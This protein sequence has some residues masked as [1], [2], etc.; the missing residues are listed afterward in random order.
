[1]WQVAL[2]IL[3]DNLHMVLAMSP[4]GSA[5]RTRCRNFPGLVSCCTIDWYFEWP[6]E[7]LLAVAN[8]F[9]TNLT[10]PDEN[11][12]DI[13]KIISYVH[14]SVT[15][16]YSP[17][18]EAKFKRRNYATPKNYLDF[19]DGYAT[20]LDTNRGKVDTM[21]TRLASGLEKLISAAEQVATMSTE[22]SE[23]VIVVNAKKKEVEALINDINTKTE[24]ANKRQGEAQ[25]MA[26][27]IEEDNVVITREK[28]GADE[29]LAEALP[30]LAAAA[31]ALENLEK[32][33]IT[34]I[35]SMA[36]PPKPVMIVCMCVVIL[37][38]LGRE[39]ESAG[40]AGAKAM[41]SDTSLLRLLQEYKKDDMKERQI[42]KIKDLLAQEPE[43]FGGS[44]EKMA[45]VSKA[46]YGLLQWVN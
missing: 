34:E 13:A 20:L 11:R 28:A 21:S 15:S 42:K 43:I 17:S 41:L 44:G 30:A 25:S 12:S 26:K 22:L 9:L 24:A 4:A 46:G 18:F 32:K 10:L 35:K 7:A 3:K 38:P 2:N 16:N 45:S 37:R 29:A 14:T 5:L 1:V 36:S 40:W 39:D 31:E 33:D 6:E 23:K 19:L 8:H 27:Q